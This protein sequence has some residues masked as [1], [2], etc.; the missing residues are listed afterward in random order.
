MD[1]LLSSG[2][3]I[4]AGWCQWAGWVV[5]R[6]CGSRVAVALGPCRRS[7]ADRRAAASAVSCSRIGV[8]RARFVERWGRRSAGRWRGVGSFDA[9]ADRVLVGA[10]AG[11]GIALPRPV[12]SALQRCRQEPPAPW[13]HE[14]FVGTWAAQ[15]PIGQ[16]WV[17]LM[18]LLLTRLGA[19]GRGG[20]SVLVARGRCRSLAASIRSWGCGRGRVGRGGIRGRRGGR[21]VRLRSGSRRPRGAG[22]RG[23]GR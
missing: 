6:S 13:A 7:R 20:A 2:V 12:E 8:V 19:P 17:S 21:A 22:W 5:G 3:G 15:P 1:A 10:G 18:L 11:T 14:L 16:R 9:G 4:D 23:T